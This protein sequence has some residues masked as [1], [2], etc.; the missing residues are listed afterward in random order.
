MPKIS[1]Q[2]PPPFE[3]YNGTPQHEN[4]SRMIE[5]FPHNTMTASPAPVEFDRGR[6]LDLPVDYEFEGRRKSVEN[7]INETDTSALL[8]LQDGKVRFES[9]F[10][11][12]GQDVQWISWSM[13]KSFISALVGI[14]IEEGFINSVND[15]IS[16]Y[17]HSL[18]GSA[19]DGVRIKEVL[20]MSSGARWSEDYSDPDADIHKLAAVMAGAATL[21]SFVSSM[22]D[23]TEPGT[24][25][26]YNSADTQ[27]LGLLLNYATGRS[28]T[29]YMKEKLVDPLGMEA[30]GHWLLDGA[31][32][33]LALGG[34]NL[35]AR[36]FAKIGEL[37]RNK[38]QWN[39]QQIVSKDWVNMSVK[40]SADHLQ[41]G[42]VIVGGHIF[43]F[44]YGY[45]WWVPEGDIGEFAAIG[46]YNQFIFVDPSRDAVIVKLS[47]NRAYGTSP[48][49][50]INRERE[51]VEFLRTLAK[52]L[53]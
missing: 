48:D 28:V 41:A 15:P 32:M 36:D 2:K 9:Y 12:G 46:V 21:E 5:L 40:P 7:F 10:L 20:Q 6:G 38:G 44:G 3:L 23:E 35:T 53:N 49:E 27:A 34:L 37:Y 43:P 25:C 30:T 8:I 52:N 39:G 14:A 47:A 42:R 13:A 45:Q 22:Q 24:V 11:T 50:C 26:Q 1:S 4:F 51:T 19:Y 16:Q 17:V 18:T 29:D 33:E 31:G